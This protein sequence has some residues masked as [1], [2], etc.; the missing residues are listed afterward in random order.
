MTRNGTLPCELVDSSDFL[1]D[2]PF[3]FEGVESFEEILELL[4]GFFFD[5]FGFENSLVRG[6]GFI[7]AFD[8]FCSD[9]FFGQEFDGRDEEVVVKPPLGFVE[10]V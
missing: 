1:I 9:T 2:C 8:G 6:F 3:K 10:V 4:L 7:V 5:V